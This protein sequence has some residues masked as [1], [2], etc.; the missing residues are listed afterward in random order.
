MRRL[1]AFL[2]SEVA[3]TVA[4]LAIALLLVRYW[5]FLLAGLAAGILIVAVV[6]TVIS[7]VTSLRS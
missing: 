2:R 7:L 4:G 3:Q 6:L 1:L 5:H